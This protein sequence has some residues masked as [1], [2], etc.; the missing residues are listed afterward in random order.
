MKRYHLITVFL[1]LSLTLSACSA[2]SQ[3]DP[4]LAARNSGN[5]ASTSGAPGELP[6]AMKLALGTFALDK[7]AHPVDAAQA[8]QLL[9]LW[10]GM[11][12]LSSDQSVATEEIQ[13]LVKQIKGTMTPEQVA[14][15]DALN[16]SFQDIPAI[17]KQVGLD[18]GSFGGGTGNFSP[19]ARSTFQAARQSG[20]GGG[21]GQFFGGGGGGG[22]PQPGAGIPGAGGGG[23][24]AST[25]T[26][27][28]S[29]TRS[30]GGSFQKLG[31]TPAMINAVIQF[32]QAKLK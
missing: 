5:T 22:N 31:V 2:S 4:S 17:S 23:F 18:L 20:G 15:I 27:N 26:S 3:A 21:G 19:E 12:A 30:N 24:A 6:E 25:N 11:R 1:L 32:L 8:T 29:Q 7:S 14:A 28:T 16:L 10:K 13:G 9:F